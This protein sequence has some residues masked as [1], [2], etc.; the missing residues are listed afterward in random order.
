MKGLILAIANPKGGTGKSTVSAN[1]AAVTA[2]RGKLALL[3]DLDPQGSSTLLSSVEDV[4]ET[5]S[6]GAMFR[7]EP[8]MPSSIAVP[9]KYGYDV[10]PAGPALIQAEDWLSHTLGG[11]LRLRML[12]NKDSALEK[13]D[14]IIVDTA[15]FKGR[16]LNSTLVCSSDVLIPIRPSV[17]STNELPDFFDII[18]QITELRE[19]MGDTPL[20]VLGL[21]FNMVKEHTS[22]AQ[23]NINEVHEALAALEQAGGARYTTTKT[24]IP[25]ATAVEEAGLLRSPVVAVRVG[26]KV[27]QR[28]QTLYDEIIE[29]LEVPPSTASQMEKVV[30]A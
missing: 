12:F 11:E 9:T 2:K 21:L 22:A 20:H 13:Y 6:A 17:L 23:Q 16:L 28:Y 3:I 4:A 8:V 5:A 26:S 29:G 18:R 27:A 24:M 1:L 15:G 14:L 25:E 19:G 10:I 7:D 30:T